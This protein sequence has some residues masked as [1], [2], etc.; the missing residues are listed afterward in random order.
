MRWRCPFCHQYTSVQEADRLITDVPLTPDLGK[1]RLRLEAQY[2]RNP[3]CKQFALSATLFKT[4]SKERAV[5]HIQGVRTER[6]ITE[7]VISTW[8]LM[9][10]SIAK[11]LP[12]YIPKPITEDYREACRISSL[13]PKASATLARRCLQ[14]MIRNFFGITERT[15]KLEIDA[16][17]GKVDLATW[18]AIDAVRMVGNIGAHMEKDIDLIVEVD[19]EEAALLIGLIELLIEEWYVMRHERGLRVKAV[20][21]LAAKKREERN[22]PAP[23]A[24]ACE[25]ELG[26]APS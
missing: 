8:S 22:P 1:H 5:G 18:Q 6:Y 14:G 21:A 11:P 25:S 3:E 23:D 13:S 9:P 16:I 7:D 17:A 15:L 10:D 19:P 12:G 4:V 24:S 20:T 26:E 2:C